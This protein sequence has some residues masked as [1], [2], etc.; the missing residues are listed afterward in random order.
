MINKYITTLIV[1]KFK[2]KYYCTN[3]TLHYFI[4]ILLIYYILI[5]LSLIK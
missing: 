1:N 2:K 3:N 4:H 5:G